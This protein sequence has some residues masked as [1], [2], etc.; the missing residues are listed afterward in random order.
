M[1]AH[2]LLAV[3]SWDVYNL[4]FH[5][6]NYESKQEAEA[7]ANEQQ[8]LSSL[9]GVHAAFHVKPKAEKLK[10]THV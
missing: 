9:G 3:T 2:N 4:W 6:G 1:T 8:K 10:A 7:V 5:H